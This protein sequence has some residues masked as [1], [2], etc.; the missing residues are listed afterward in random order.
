MKSPCI[1]CEF[2]HK[3][4]N[5]D[6]CANC[7]KRIEYARE[8][9]MISI[10]AVEGDRAAREETRKIREIKKPKSD[11]KAGETSEKKRGRPPK[12]GVNEAKKAKDKM[13]IKGI[14]IRPTEFCAEIQI[15]E[16]LEGVKEIANSE[17]R[18]LPQQVLW[19]LKERVEEW[20]KEDK[21]GMNA[22]RKN[23]P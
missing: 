15:N 23:T 2:E 6:L 5:N 20:K 11:L 13:L 14:Y 18:S 3:D 12:E 7:E 19:I 8:H 1:G 17:L 22:R 16:I 4:K 9:G 21:G 10:E